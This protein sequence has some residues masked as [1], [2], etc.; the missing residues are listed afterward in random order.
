[1]GGWSEERREE[2]DGGEKGDNEE[3][4]GGEGRGG[5]NTVFVFD[6]FSDSR[7]ISHSQIA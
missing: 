3:R 2:R 7:G 5:A 4:R 6:V 1:M